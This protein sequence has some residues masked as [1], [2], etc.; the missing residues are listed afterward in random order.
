MGAV[1][2]ADLMNWEGIWFI[3]GWK[4][5]IFPSGNENS[6]NGPYCQWCGTLSSPLGFDSG[7]SCSYP[8]WVLAGN[9]LDYSPLFVLLFKRPTRGPRK[10]VW[11]AVKPWCYPWLCYL[12]CLIS[13]HENSVRLRT[14]LLPL[15]K[16]VS[17]DFSH[18][19]GKNNFFS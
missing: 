9:L 17:G 3:E 16:M 2:L 10:G 1:A 11:E 6:G 19:G 7:P 8:S 13:V 14:L 15:R 18:Q 12:L 4:W 5:W